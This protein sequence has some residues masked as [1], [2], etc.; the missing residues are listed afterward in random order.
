MNILFLFENAIV[1]HIG[2]V[3]RVT[4]ILA[5][6]LLSRGHK[7]A[8]LS[9][10]EDPA[11]YDYQYIAPQY[12]IDCKKDKEPIKEE[13]EKILEKENVD[14]VINQE[15][16][17][18]THY[19]LSITPESVKKI[20]CLHIQPFCT[21]NFGRMMLK[22]MKC[23]N[24]KELLYVSFC[25]LFPAYYLK[26]TLNIETARLNKSLEVSDYLCFLSEKFIPR[27]LKYMPTVEKKRLVAVNNPATFEF[28]KTNE[29]TKEKTIIWVGRQSNSPKNI[30]AFIDVWKIISKSNKDWK[31]IIIGDGGD[32]EYNKKYAQKNAVER[33]KFAG[34]QKDVEQFYQKASLIGMTSTYEGWGMVL[35]EAMSYGCIPFAYD[36]YES[37]H[38]IIDDNKN[39]IIVKPF[40]K[41]EMAMRIQELIDDKEK[42]T[43]MQKAAIEKVK[44]FSVENI[45]DKWE[46][47]LDYNHTI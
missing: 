32:L 14:I 42:F 23:N 20:T 6:E 17:P 8:F 41:K 26:Q 43:A 40:N 2:G 27:V 44:E 9:I 35:T 37:V 38:D 39:G 47:I 15:P 29:Q 22:Y 18:D 25:R 19:L 3:Q 34:L 5:E 12:F 24:W 33:L 30:P 46:K 36:T 28:L 10:A 31:A 21:Q 4:H 13:Y 1:P 7:V 16:R 11:K 45:V